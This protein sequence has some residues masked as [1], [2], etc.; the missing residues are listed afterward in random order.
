[1]ASDNEQAVVSYPHVGMESW[2]NPHG[3]TI[4]RL[5]YSAD[6][7]KSEG[8]KDFVPEINKWLSPWALNA[9]NRMTDPTLYLKE[10]EIDAEA[11][12]GALLFRLDESVTC[13]KSFP[14][15]KEWTRRM[16]LDPHPGI[17][18]A[19]LWVATDPWGDRWY[20]RELWPSKVAYRWENGALHG[21]PGPC[22]QDEHGPNIL[23]Y[24]QTIKY[25][26]SSENPE[27]VEN[28]IAFDEEMF[29]RVVDYAAR[30]FGKGTNDDPEQENYQQ[31]YERH[32]QEEGLSRVY[33]DDAKKDRQ[34][35]VELVNEGLK[36]I[37]VM[38]NDGRYKKSS[39]IHI[40]SDRCPEL[41]FQ[42]KNNRRQQLSPVQ[43]ERQDPTGKPVKVRNH[44]T[45]CLRYVEMCNPIYVKEE[46]TQSTFEPLAR[47]F[48]Y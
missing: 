3:I 40:F 45:D 26:E 34:V 23:E 13:E 25:L 15:P 5:H 10:Y 19:F 47:G 42:L 6:P 44:M 30:A 4:L 35:G 27:N 43:I 48:S 21:K 29:E 8:E 14:I 28:G 20:F 1:M 33:F 2:K 41:I 16:A 36:V 38:G 18:H 37:E 32:M 22:P 9:Y 12:L 46:D 31:R 24:V 7:M 39:H 17:P 11:A